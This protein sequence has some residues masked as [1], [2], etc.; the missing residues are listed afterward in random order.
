MTRWTHIQTKKTRLHHC[1]Q[2]YNS[3]PSCYLN[4]KSAQ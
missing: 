1:M 4:V 3:L 2:L